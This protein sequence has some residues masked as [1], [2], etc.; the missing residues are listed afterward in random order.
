MRSGFMF[1]L[2]KAIMS[3]I[4]AVL[5]PHRAIGIENLPAQ[6]GFVLCVNHIHAR[7]P[8]FVSTVIPMGRKLFFMAKKELFKSKIVGTFLSWLGAFPVDRGGARG[9]RAGDLPAGH[10]Q[11]NQRADPVSVRRIDD[12]AARRRAGDS[13]LHRR[14][15][16]AVPPFGHSLRRAA[17][18]FRAWNALRSEHAGE[19]DKADRGRGMGAARA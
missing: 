10:A 13:L 15:L 8:F 7:D 5:F 4:Y 1:G 2:A 12:R 16:P 18:S 3:P 9:Q 14:S 19:R 17:G 6:G 11:Q